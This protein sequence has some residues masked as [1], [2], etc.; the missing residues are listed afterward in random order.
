MTI[1]VLIADDHK[2]FRQGLIS[3]MKT[4]PDLVEVVGEAQSG[5]EAVSGSSW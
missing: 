2:L 4:R 1:K 5:E 3:L